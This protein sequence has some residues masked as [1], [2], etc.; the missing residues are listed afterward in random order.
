MAPLLA[1]PTVK[2]IVLRRGNAVGAYASQRRALLTAP[3]LQVQQPGNVSVRIDPDELQDHLA[4]YE[5]CYATYSR[6]LAGQA[7]HGVLYEGLCGSARGSTFRGIADFLG[8]DARVPA[9]LAQTA[10]ET[11]ASVSNREE[12]VRAFRQ[13]VRRGKSGYSPAQLIQLQQ[14]VRQHAKRS[15]RSG[16]S[17]SR[18]RKREENR[19]TR[20]QWQGV[21]D[22]NNGTTTEYRRCHF[23]SL[24]R[25]S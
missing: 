15:S 18:A 24:L 7:F 1:D 6:L 5:S 10:R 25:A 16:W 4:N 8:P 13:T 12:L 9:P 22:R 21:V 20:L 17:S 23:R 3:F 2:N 14:P 19:T 11:L